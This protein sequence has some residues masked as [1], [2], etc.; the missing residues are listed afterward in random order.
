MGEYRHRMTVIVPEN[1]IEEANHLALIAGES[2]DD[3][4][5]F[6]DSNWQDINGYKYAICSA[7]IKP[8]VLSLLGTPLTDSVLTAEGVNLELA[9][10]ALDLVVLYEED[11]ILNLNHIT[12]AI[13]KDPLEVLQALGLEHIELTSD[14][15]V[16]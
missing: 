8:I 16:L 5:T 10:A 1:M 11:D 15:E 9:Q 14:I 3:I 7:A 12:I 13:D 4:N 2:P 6:K